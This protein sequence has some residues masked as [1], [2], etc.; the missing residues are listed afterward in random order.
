MI[1]DIN[2]DLAYVEWMDATHDDAAA[3]EAEFRQ[4]MSDWMESLCEG[5]ESLRGDMM[6]ATDYCDGT[7]R[8]AA[9]RSESAY[10]EYLEGFLPDD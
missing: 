6:G 1:M 2:E 10:L 5:H 4:G 7:C 3:S 8:P 9:E